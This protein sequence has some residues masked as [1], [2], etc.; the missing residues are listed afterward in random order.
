ME[1]ELK[2]LANSFGWAIS[3]SSSLERDHIVADVA[4]RTISLSRRD[5]SKDSMM[6]ILLMVTGVYSLNEYGRSIAGCSGVAFKY[7][8]S[9]NISGLEGPL[10]WSN[11]CNSDSIFAI[12]AHTSGFAWRGMMTKSTMNNPTELKE[13]IMAEITNPGKK[14]EVMRTSLVG[15]DRSMQ[16]AGHIYDLL[17]DT[18]PELKIPILQRYSNG[19]YSTFHSILSLESYLEG[20][21]TIDWD[22]NFPLLVFENNLQYSD[23]ESLSPE[24]DRPPKVRTLSEVILDHYELCGVVYHSGAQPV[25][26]SEVRTIAKES[27]LGDHYYSKIKALD[28]QWYLY[29]D[30]KPVFSPTNLKRI[31]RHQKDPAVLFFY[32]RTIPLAPRK[33]VVS[34]DLTIEV[35]LDLL[36]QIPFEGN[37]SRVD[38]GRGEITL[39]PFSPDFTHARLGKEK[40]SISFRN[41]PERMAFERK[42]R[43][44]LD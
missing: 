21:P 3:F 35:S 30:T 16:R 39:Q 29:D 34:S 40:V 24:K 9:Y 27:K 42:L 12:L 6:M 10:Y 1:R 13:K 32:Q 22:I 37:Y 41:T 11:S 25:T 14:C 31:S 28:G 19:D 38:I 36:D 5:I 2:K 20:D 7:K 17:T 4:L 26:G 33:I 8:V 23:I 15:G 18:F 44:A 43:G